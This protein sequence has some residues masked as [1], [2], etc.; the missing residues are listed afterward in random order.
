MYQEMIVFLTADYTLVDILYSV[1]LKFNFI[2]C[3]GSTFSWLRAHR[4]YFPASVVEIK[5]MFWEMLNVALDNF[6]QQPE[7][8]CFSS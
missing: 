4:P 5:D 3:T 2:L 8:V 7:E 6:V 1:Y